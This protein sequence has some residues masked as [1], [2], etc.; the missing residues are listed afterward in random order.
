MKNLLINQ[1]GEGHI[2][3]A[4]LIIIAVVVGGLLI[5]GLYQ[6]FGGE[7]GILTK[8]NA[9]VNSLMNYGENVSL[10]CADVLVGDRRVLRYSYDGTHWY[11]C[12]TPS[13][14]ETTTVYR[15]VSDYAEESPVSVALLQDG[16]NYYILSSLDG[17]ITW[18]Q[19][20]NFTAQGITHC[21][22][23]TSAQLPKTAGSFSGEHF[24]IRY[25]GGGQNYFTMVSDGTVWNTGWSD[26]VRP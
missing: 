10:R 24:V 9:E 23:G 19:K 16:N 14:S 26:I 1:R 20:Y 5:V 8:A 22:Y 17:G 21:Y 4:V 2:K 25:W 11:D 6:L 18:T 13:Y 15:I 3:T 7:D 12:E